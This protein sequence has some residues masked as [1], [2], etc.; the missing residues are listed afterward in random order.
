M[1]EEYMEKAQV[2]KAEVRQNSGTKD[3]AKL[4][5]QGQI[6]V[7]V[8]GHKQKP[9]SISL[10]KRSFLDELHLGHRLMEVQIA[11]KKETVLVKAVQYDHLGS[12]IIHVDLMLVDV[13]EMV[14]VTVPI[15][16]KGTAKGTHEGG[17]VEIHSDRIEVECLVTNIPERI[18]FSIKEMIL[19][20]SIHAKD[21]PLPEGVKLI[22]PPELL[23]A[24][25]H[26]VAE[27]KTT[28][29]LEAAMPAAPEVI[30]AVKEEAEEGA[31][32]SETKEAKE[33]KEKKEEKKEKKK[34]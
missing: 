6:P 8:Y 1:I 28:E 29:E 20:D 7:I 4:R 15:E 10:N 18:T 31:E 21:I 26:E 32:A 3:S 13:T 16:F 24:T 27:V 19:G 33:P 30:T 9:M 2:L 12:E 23:M 17:M 34:E 22:T 5:K 11:D 14:K 25:C